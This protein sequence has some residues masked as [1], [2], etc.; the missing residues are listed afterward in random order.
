MEETV[1]TEEGISLIDLVKLLLSKIK[2]L[3]VLTL[4]GAIIGGA[5]GF[6]TTYGQD[7]YGTLVR[8]YINPKRSESVTENTSQYGVYGAY[9][10]HV[11]DNMTKLLSSESFAER[12]L[13]EENGLPKEG[14]NSAIDEKRV[15]ALAAIN[16]VDGVRSEKEAWEEAILDIA[17]QIKDLNEDITEAK[18]DE[19]FFEKRLS[20]AQNEYASFIT[21]IGNADSA[22]A[23]ALQ[24]AVADAKA[25]RDIAADTRTQLEE[26]LNTQKEY[27]ETA[28]ETLET[29]QENLAEKM[30]I[31][32]EAI[33]ATLVEWRKTPSYEKGITAIQSAVR[34]SYLEEGEELE[35]ANDLAR[36]FIRVN[37]SVLQNQEF[38]EKLLNLI[39][40]TVPEFVKENMAV[41][42]GY[43]GTNCEPSTRIHKIKLLNPNYSM[44]QTVKYA[45][46]MAVLTLIIAC[47]AVILID[48][49]DKRLRDHETITRLFD[50]PVLGIV[51]SIKMKT[52]ATKNVKESALNNEKEEK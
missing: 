46:L 41:P 37:I 27:L 11:M 44:S 48:R 25:K 42:S 47:V 19:S 36:S 40:E 45:A 30:E 32:N 39:I 3:I 52:N 10:K 17:E 23:K 34:Y 18:K 5:F 24:K 7:Y 49:S 35:N 29:I 2:L 43:E 28:N 4:V 6:I 13:V 31:A 38:A 15:V 14:I 16:V 1:K 21:A 9:G 50:L 26:E 20:E 33:E 12:L 8:F 51:P 22:E